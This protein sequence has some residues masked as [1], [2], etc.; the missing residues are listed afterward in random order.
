[1]VSIRTET[2]FGPTSES[3]IIAA[4]SNE[5]VEAEAAFVLELPNAALG[6]DIGADI[7]LHSHVCG[8]S[9]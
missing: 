5:A 2:N 1:M 8:R 6:L 9:I 3:F 4:S 7:T